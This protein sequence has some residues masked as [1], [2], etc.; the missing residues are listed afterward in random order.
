MKIST[1]CVSVLL[2]AL[3]GCGGVDDSKKLS[4]LSTEEAKDV[5]LELV[6]DYPEKTVT[7]SGATITIGLT[8]ADCDGETPA[9][10]NCT[11]TV[12][13]TRDC[14]AA[15]YAQAEACMVDAPLP[16]ACAKLSG[17]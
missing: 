3:V 4:E 14:T 7:C 10:A 11:A 5:C 17:C 12:G 9:S 2:A 6:D 1:G 8:A 16:A 15:I 13:D